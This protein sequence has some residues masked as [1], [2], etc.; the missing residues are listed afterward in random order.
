MTIIICRMYKVHINIFVCFSCQVHQ[1]SDLFDQEQ[2]QLK[3]AE[4]TSKIKRDFPD[5]KIP[6]I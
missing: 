6:D 1:N 3:R 5:L 2:V 4:A